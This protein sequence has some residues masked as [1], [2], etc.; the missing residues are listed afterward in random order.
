MPKSHL[1]TFDA[2]SRKT[3]KMHEQNAD[4]DIIFETK[5]DIA[6]ILEM[7]KRIRNRVDERAPWKEGDKVATIPAV[8]YWNLPEHIRNDPEEFD[9]WLNH[10][11]QEPFR[12]RSGQV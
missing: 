12:T 9:K 5:A 3:L 10:S 1:V 4:G 11:D 7:N 8:V 6:P 2:V